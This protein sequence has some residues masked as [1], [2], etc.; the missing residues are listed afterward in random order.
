MAQTAIL[1]RETKTGAAIAGL[2]FGAV[3]FAPWVLAGFRPIPHP[4]QMIV[5][6][7][8]T[9]LFALGAVLL[10]VAS[11]PRSRGYMFARALAFG[12]AATVPVPLV[13]WIFTMGLRME[14]EPP[15]LLLTTLWGLSIG[16]V[17][18]LVAFLVSPKT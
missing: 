4:D 18:S 11:R 15:L 10:A 5:P 8:V 1:F 2:A 14:D 6:A 9:P 3:C 16:V 13:S 7:V 17:G 12:V